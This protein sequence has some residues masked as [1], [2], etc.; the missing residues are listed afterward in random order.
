MKNKRKLYITIIIGVFLI[1]FI[2]GVY[3]GLTHYFYHVKE[4]ALYKVETAYRLEGE[5]IASVE[6][7][8]LK[9][10][11]EYL[12]IEGLKAFDLENYYIA[13]ENFEKALTASK[14]DKALPTYLYYYMNQCIYMQEDYG[15]L[16][17][18]SSAMKEAKK[19][20]PLAND[21][22]MIWNLISSIS[23]A[24][25]MDKKAIEI[26]EDYLQENRYLELS[27]W[28][29]I[30]NYIAMLEYNNEEYSNSIRNFYD[31]EV[32]LEN[33]KLTPQLQYELQYAKEYIA[34]IYAIFED[35]EKAAV[36]YQEIYNTSLENNDFSSYACCINMASAYLEIS[37]T[38]NAR[39]AM[40]N[41]TKNLD[42]TDEMYVP[43]IEATMWDIYANIC[44]MEGDYD[45]ADNYLKK[46]EDFYEKNVGYAFLGGEYFVLL[47]RCKYLVNQ[48]DI[49]LA[50][51]KLEAFIED[52]KAAYLGL[53]DEIYELLETVYQQTGQKD[54]L[55]SMYKKLLDTNK[56]F[57][58]TT[59]REYLKFSEY[60]RENNDLKEYNSKLSRT[61]LIAIFTTILISVILIFVLMLVRLLSKRNITDQLTG[62]YNRTK[63]NILLQKYKRN[64]TPADLAVVMMD[65]DYFKRYNDTYGHQAGD[66]VLKEVA[67]VLKD[68]VYKKDIVIRYGGE[69]FLILLNGVKK[70]AAE[71][72]C[73][74]IHTKLKE[75]ALPHNSSE[76]SEYVTM[77]MG[78][79][80]Q[81]EKNGSAL[82]KLIGSADECLYH[83][84]EAG[85]NRLTVKDN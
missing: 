8:F 84:K 75:L 3:K 65:I 61:N 16:E 25:A 47:S 2:L 27:T 22:E 13:Q 9:D 51:T 69:E 34:N 36:L 23:Y 54:K 48:G 50:L 6:N 64:G 30:K 53:E 38:E 19:Y 18:V 80:Y 33:S 83:S 1:L 63:L 76:V 81:K 44:M 71:D 79:V 56:D 67:G 45:Q 26:L 7:T 78:L 73:Q 60:Y 31:V 66:K 52:D 20:I 15:D 11:G 29:W 58:T 5:D 10:S 49:K 4:S 40:E 46:A 85:R 35:Y 42:K 72:I 59:Q 12:F 68:S 37:D 24:E 43:E 70:K 17:L 57:I 14:K 82:E 55:I 32:K 41:L 74:K 28:A 21:N 62:V 39:K 77:S